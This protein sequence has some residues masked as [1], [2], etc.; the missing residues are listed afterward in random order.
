MDSRMYRNYVAVMIELCKQHNTVEQL[1]MFQKLFSLLVV[2]ELFF[3]RSAGAGCVGVD[4]LSG[5]CQLI[6]GVQLGSSCVTVLSGCARLDKGEDPHDK[7]LTNQ[8]ICNGPVGMA[9]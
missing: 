6:E 3:A 7:E 9:Q 1:P 5:G 4:R 8:R 2:R